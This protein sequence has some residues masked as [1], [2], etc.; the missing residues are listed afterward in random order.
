MKFSSVI[1]AIHNNKQPDCK[2]LEIY[3]FSSFLELPPSKTKNYHSL[4]CKIYIYPTRESLLGSRMGEILGNWSKSY[5]DQIK[6]SKR[7]EKHENRIFQYWRKGGR[8]CDRFSLLLVVEFLEEVDEQ[9]WRRRWQSHVYVLH[10]LHSRMACRVRS[11][12]T[13]RH[14]LLWTASS[15]FA[16]HPS[17]FSTQLTQ[18]SVAEVPFA[19]NS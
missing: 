9:K 3:F 14:F 10:L 1:K 16:V 15:S 6:I 18:C 4:L 5:P 11:R 12:T 13:R 7:I 17:D 19:R 2:F 8:I